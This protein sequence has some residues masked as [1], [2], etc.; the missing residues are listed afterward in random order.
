MKGII[1]TIAITLGMALG[2]AASGQTPKEMEV[3]I[4]LAKEADLE[5]VWAYEMEKV[6]NK[7]AREIA[8]IRDRLAK[9]LA[10]THAKAVGKAKVTP[11]QLSAAIGL[12]LDRI[13]W[14]RREEQCARIEREGPKNDLDVFTDC[15]PFKK[16][17]RRKQ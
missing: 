4:Q 14:K 16:Q 6:E 15:S 1:V 5:M 9:E 10:K 11:S 3:L 2:G 12:M 7:R 17:N 8:K 13:K